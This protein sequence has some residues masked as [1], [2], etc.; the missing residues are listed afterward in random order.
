MELSRR[1]FLFGTGAALAIAAMPSI[2]FVKAE[3]APWS[4]TR[5]IYDFTFNA[6][7]PGL[8]EKLITLLLRRN[9]Q[10]LFNICM[11]QRAMYRWV[12]PPG[13]E[14]YMRPQDVWGF[15][16]EPAYESAQL[17]MLF[18]D[19]NDRDFA[20]AI[21]WPG[22]EASTPN[23]LRLDNDCQEPDPNETLFEVPHAY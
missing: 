3:L 18:R 8:D 4:G 16:I 20:Q 21:L 17:F 5:R 7:N 22:M 6:N 9:D 13:G 12:S 14:L 10:V 15:D 2:P 11:N 19:E 23:P 1:G